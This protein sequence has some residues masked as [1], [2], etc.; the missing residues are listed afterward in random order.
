MKPESRAVLMSTGVVL[1]L[2]LAVALSA[3]T[4]PAEAA[5]NSSGT[6]SL[7]TPGNP[8]TTGNT[9]SSSWANNTLTDIGSELTNSLD[10]NGRGAMLAALQLYSGSVSS[11]GLTWSSE[12]SSGLYRAASNDFGMSVAGAR[13]QRWQTTGSSVTGTLAVSGATT[14]STTLAVT[15]AS[16]LTGAV[17]APGGVTVGSGGTAISGSYGATYNFTEGLMATD[18]CDTVSETLTGVS[19][20]GVCTVST[21]GELGGGSHKA[22]WVDCYVSGANTVVIRL[23]NASGANFTFGAGNYRIRVFQP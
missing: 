14:L 10:R 22:V 20:G 17:A 7:Y 23:C 16:T 8:V 21:D 4:P 2:A 18:V 9:I 1:G 12:T 11:P 3:R 19:A 15:G 6:Y 13:V 5:R